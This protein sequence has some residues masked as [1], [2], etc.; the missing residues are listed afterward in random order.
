MEAN[1]TLASF[2]YL[3][4]SEGEAESDHDGGHPGCHGHRAVPLLAERMADSDV[5]LHGET[6]HERG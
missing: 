4:G 5:S 3:R 2:C 1:G 6:E